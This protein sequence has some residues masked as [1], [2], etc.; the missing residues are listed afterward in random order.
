MGDVYFCPD[1]A[2]YLYE[3]EVHHVESGSSIPG[4][5]ICACGSEVHDTG[6]VELLDC[7]NEFKSLA[8][9]RTRQRDQL[10]EVLE[11]ITSNYLMLMGIPDNSSVQPT[12][13]RKAKEVIAQVK[14]AQGGQP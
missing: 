4:R 7:A 9:I 8:K 5:P 11:E 14:E 10:L 1:C 2:T 6:T 3:D 12:E 13:A